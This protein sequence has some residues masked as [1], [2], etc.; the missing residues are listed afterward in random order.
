MDTA[1]MTDMTDKNALGSAVCPCENR[2]SCIN[3]SGGF[4]RGGF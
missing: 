1:E 2:D 3:K 4:L